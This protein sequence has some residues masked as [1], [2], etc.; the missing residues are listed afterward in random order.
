[1]HRSA[2]A[3]TGIIDLSCQRL[4]NLHCEVEELREQI[5]EE[6]RLLVEQWSVLLRRADFLPGARNLAFHLALRRRDLRGLQHELM[7]YGLSSL[8]GSGARG[9]EALNAVWAQLSRVC[10]RVPSHSLPVP[11]DMGC[12]AKRLDAET[13]AVFGPPS[14]ARRV[15]TMVT[16]PA[17]MEGDPEFA[18][19]LLRQGVELVRIDLARDDKTVWRAQ[20]ETFREAAAELEQPLRI[21]AE[22]GGPKIRTLRFG[23]VGEKRRYA[24]GDCFWLVRA[25][26]ELP[27]GEAG[28]G[29]SQ[30]ELI[31]QLRCGDSVWIDSGELGARV[32]ERRFGAVRLEVT[33]APVDGKRLKEGKSLNFPDTEMA[34][35]ALS[36][37]D[38]EVLPFAAAHADI[39][40]YSFVQGA[41]DVARLQTAL[42]DCVR[43][44]AAP[45]ALM[46]KIETRRAVRNLPEIIVSAAGRN[47]TTVM[48][49]RSE[50]AVEMGHE[51]LLDVQDGILSLCEAAGVPVVWAAPELDRLARRG[52]PRRREVADAVACVRGEC[53]MFNKGPHL[54][55]AVNLLAEALL[56]KEAGSDR[57]SPGLD[58]IRSWQALFEA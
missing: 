12:V 35:A 31:G 36:E 37:A 22:L 39:I 46:M 5:S 49:S 18:R 7:R 21:L 9:P 47:P 8:D 41:D 40:A 13:C 27:R 23:E 30:P 33:Q 6:A 29:C 48:L 38:L 44:S 50:L 34:V 10:G 3:D 58:A 52:E 25:P 28:I 19:S 32:V 4:A 2:P 45:L 24:E 26:S 16:L 14:Q 17:A 51:R 53:V 55:R 1:M 56:R 11:G 54:L 57:K 15:R 43:R 42:D 20:I